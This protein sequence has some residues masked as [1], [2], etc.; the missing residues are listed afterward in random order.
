MKGES[1]KKILTTLPTLTVAHRV[2]TFDAQA[3][4]NGFVHRTWATQPS[5]DHFT[6]E[7]S[8]DA[9]AFEAIGIVDGAGYAGTSPKY[10]FDDPN[11]Y[12]GTGCVRP[13]STAR[14]LFKLR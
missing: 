14:C 4:E 13:T 2:L 1:G 8:R 6:V 11:P 10:A 7:R 5:N 9:V 12:D 3:L